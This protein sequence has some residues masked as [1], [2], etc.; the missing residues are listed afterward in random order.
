LAL[1]VIEI[2]K[3]PAAAA[4]SIQSGDSAD[5]V[6]AVQDARARTKVPGHEARHEP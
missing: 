6:A 1:A 5:S 3:L 2:S 4:T